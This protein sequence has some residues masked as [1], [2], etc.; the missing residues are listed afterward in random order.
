[1]QPSQAQPPPLHPCRLPT[2]TPQPYLEQP[3]SDC[4]QEDHCVV[5]D[6]GH[7]HGG[8]ARGPEHGRGLQGLQ[9]RQRVLQVGSPAVQLLRLQ[10]QEK[11]YVR[12]WL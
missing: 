4:A 1:M 2:L 8:E 3:S 5:A 6:A 10:L 9:D 12:P 7:G 11:L